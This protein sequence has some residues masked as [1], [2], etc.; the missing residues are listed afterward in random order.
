MELGKLLGIPSG[1]R[2]S[3]DLKSLTG[4]G[5]LMV[6]KVFPVMGKAMKPHAKGEPSAVCFNG[7][8]GRVEFVNQIQEDERRNP[9]AKEDDKCGNP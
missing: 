4:K 3:C 5:D 2:V 9:H 7:E 6:V 8:G 1:D